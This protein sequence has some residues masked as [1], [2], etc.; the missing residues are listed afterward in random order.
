MHHPSAG[1]F[2][3]HGKG[4]ADGLGEIVKRTADAHPARGLKYQIPKHCSMY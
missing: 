4:A 3:A 1:V 2:C